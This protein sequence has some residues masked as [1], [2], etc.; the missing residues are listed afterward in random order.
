MCTAISLTYGLDKNPILGRNMDFDIPIEYSILFLPKAYDYGEDLM[1]NPLKS[2]Y[3]SLGLCFL[4]HNPLK[5]GINSMGLMGISNLYIGMR[6][7]SNKIVEGK[8]NLSSLDYL[9]YALSNYDSVDSLLKDLDNINLANR[10]SMG[11]KV[12]APDF[13]YYFVD[14]N[15]KEVILEPQEGKL[16]PKDPI[17]KVMTNSPNLEAHI[18]R[19]DRLI[20]SKKNISLAKDLPGGYDPN[21]RYVKAALLLEKLPKAE[22][23]KDSLSYGYSI[24]DSLKLPEGFTLTPRDHTYTRYQTFYDSKNLLLTVKSHMGSRILVYKLEDFIKDG[25]RKI[26]DVPQEFSL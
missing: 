4:K 16:I 23:V 1:A 15:A 8:V 10:N 24:L 6:R 5:D 3:P 2:K 25:Q 18:K 7:H 22:N 11:N 20:N 14:K 13:H 9:N 21:S 19:Y 17:H 26:I 12:I